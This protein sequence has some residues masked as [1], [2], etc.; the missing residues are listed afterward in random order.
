MSSSTPTRATTDLNLLFGI[1]AVQMD[2]VTRD[3]LI[4]AMSAWVLDKATPLGQILR[5]QRALDEDEHA[6]LEALVRKHL[7]KH[8]GDPARSLAAVGA[9]QSVRQDLEQVADPDLHASLDHILVP[10]L[11]AEK[12]PATQPSSTD[13]GDAHDPYATCSNSVGTLTS[14]GLR[15]RVLRPHAKGGLGIVF[16]AHDQELRRE[17]ALKEMQDQHADR[18][19]SRAR[20]LLEAEIT[21]GLEHPGI[22]PVYGLGHYEGGRPYYA[23]RFIRGDS[24]KE[25]IEGFH[26]ADVP[27]RDPGGRALALRQLLGR[28][29]D[30][31][32][33]IAYA[34][35]RGVLHRD[36]KPGNIMLGRFGE[37]LVVDWGLAK[38]V[39]RGAGDGGAG[40]G[41]LQPASA[42]GSSAT[43]LGSA[44]GT[45]AFMS[46]E[47]AAGRLDLLGP[48][49]DVY[50]LG[51][52]LYCLLTGKAAVEGKDLGEVLR[53]VQRGEFPPPRQV[54][55]EVPQA[56]E[57]VCLKAMALRPK[58]RYPT[59]RALADDVEKWLADEPVS[60]WREP[61]RVRAGRWARRHQPT[62]AA[63]TA[64][65]L[66]AVLAGGAG[67]W[68]LGE[69]NRLLSEEQ[70]RTEQALERSQR[71]E[72]SASEQRQLALKTVRRVVDRIHARLKDSPNQQELRKDLLNEALEGLKEVERAADTSQADHATIW[73]LFELGA[74]FKDIEVGGLAEARNQ[75]ERANALARRVAESDPR[76]TQAQR[77]LAASLN[78]VGDVRLRLGDTKGAL[79]ADQEALGISR[80]LTEADPRSA[81]ARGG[82]SVALN[83]MGNVR[84]RL[85]DTKGALDAYQE[86]LGIRRKLAEADPR[87]A[88]ARRDLSFALDRLGDVQLLLGDTKGALDAYQEALGI[89]RKLTEADAGSAQAQRDLSGA[90][91]RLGNVR[92]RL[93]DTK[94]A[95]GAYQ[96]A[97]GIRRKLA[98]ADPRS[99]QA[100][101]DLPFALN[102]MGDVRL[103]LG[104]TKGALD[105]YQEALGIRR[106]L[107]E[108]D[109]GQAADREGG[110]GLG[111]GPA[112]GHR[113]AGGRGDRPA[114]PGRQEAGRVEGPPL[115]RRCFSGRSCIYNNM[116][117]KEGIVAHALNTRPAG[118][119]RNRAVGVLAAWFLLA[120][121]GSLLGVFDSET[122]PPILLGLAAVVPVAGFA[123]CYLTSR[124]FQDFVLSLD[125]RILTLAQTWRVGGIV[126]LVLYRQGA[127]PGVFALPAGW[128]GRRGRDHRAARRLVLEAPLPLQNVRGVE[129]VGRR[130]S[131]DGREPGGSRLGDPGG[132]PGR[133]RDHPTHGP[134]PAEFDPDVLR[135]PAA[136]LS[137]D[138]FHPCPKGSNL[139]EPST[140]EVR[141]GC[142]RPSARAFRRG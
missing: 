77:D 8:G 42:G 51:A 48:A 142:C 39:G 36:L 107:A 53:K 43:Q 47:Q 135:A 75:Y 29:V 105:A 73:A 106:K 37:T 76:S 52:T 6:L 84:L 64:G 112:P 11:P 122:R 90:L 138:L 50:S 5:E 60:A 41:P 88:Q 70:G 61:L 80:K 139:R 31:C 12:A 67:A 97:L 134:V 17:V 87:S 49:S 137:P 28:F 13:Q 30:V 108:A 110:P 130:R 102:G 98:E 81:Q 58:D 103:R 133:G 132:R 20:F 86:A 40:E 89:N 113:V 79:D 22:V 118:G 54:K 4:A 125:L 94:G 111:G 46:P 72:H 19:D 45:P 92:L 115:T 7:L 68:W 21:G 14:S 35:S 141:R 56:L 32:D 109:P 117:R 100:R 44:I 16:V 26:R 65:L 1:L 24:L 74:I 18:A 38:A 114:R 9:V 95:L 99:A 93:G 128:G 136:D 63:C 82:L 59:A 55:R 116:A 104:D 83:R 33:A 101:G 23:M 131:G 96:E 69:K 123:V 85:G 140:A 120:L 71:A 119:V 57:A 62:V 78:Y 127:L 91:E 34:H 25:A 66:V 126:F 27:G 124:S 129:R 15:F 121:A 10:R 2:F 3:Q